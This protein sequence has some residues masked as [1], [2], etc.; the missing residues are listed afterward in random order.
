MITLIDAEWFFKF[1]HNCMRNWVL[2]FQEDTQPYSFYVDGVEI[3]G[4]L[5]EA[6]SEDIL[7]KCEY[8]VDIVYQPQ[9]IFKVRA[10][11]RCSSTLPGH[12]EAVLFIKFSPDGRYGLILSRF[13]LF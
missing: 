8:D 6:L 13:M 5:E 11:T 3:T 4:S 12:A 7:R 10:V 2:F 9:A 1:Y